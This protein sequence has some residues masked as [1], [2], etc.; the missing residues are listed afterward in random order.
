MST[1][2]KTFS[3][4]VTSDAPIGYWKMDEVGNVNRIDSI[5]GVIQA[6][7]GVGVTSAPGL[8]GNAAK[9]SVTNAGDVSALTTAAGPKMSPSGVG[10]SLFFWIN[11]VAYAAGPVKQHFKVDFLQK[12]SI[13]NLQFEMTFEFADIVV[14]RLN[15]TATGMAPPAPAAFFPTADQWYSVYF[16]HDQDGN[17]VGYEL[18]QNN[19]LRVSQ[20]A[21]TATIVPAANNPVL[22]L[23]MFKDDAIAGVKSILWDEAAVFGQLLT[24]AQRAFMRNGGAGRQWPFTLPP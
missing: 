19:I 12:D 9:F 21:A 11:F 22:N 13:G 23:S 7:G 17:S 8:I 24:P 3:L 14:A 4:D 15:I 20:S 10:T 16:F 18:Y 5:K 1:C 6:P 2:L